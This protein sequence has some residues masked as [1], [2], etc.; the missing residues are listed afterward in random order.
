MIDIGTCLT[1]LKGLAAANDGR[2][3]CR[4]SSLRALVH[5]L[6]RLAEI[7]TALRVSEH[8]VVHADLVQH[9]RRD[10][11]RESAALFPM[12]VLR[13]NM[14]VRSLHRIGNSRQRRGRRANHNIHLRI[15]HQRSQILHQLRP[16]RNRIVHFPVARNNRS[17]CHM[18]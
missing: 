13:P 6:V 14:D 2:D 8:A 3:A 1:D 5:T 18:S 11:A 4:K 7:I 12:H 10:L 15:L 17:P 16:C 9:F